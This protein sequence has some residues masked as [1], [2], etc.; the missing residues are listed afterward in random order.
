MSIT[1]LPLYR[2]IQYAGEDSSALVAYLVTPQK[3]ETDRWQD[4]ATLD[5]HS[6]YVVT[7]RLHRLRIN[8]WIVVLNF[9]WRS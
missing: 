7:E 8:L 5:W 9:R 1:L 6:C 2:R 4:R 3:F